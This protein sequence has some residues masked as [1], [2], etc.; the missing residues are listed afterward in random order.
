ML[1]GTLKVAGSLC[2]S[3]AAGPIRQNSARRI[4]RTTARATTRP[5]AA[6]GPRSIWVRYH[7]P[8]ENMLRNFSSLFTLFTR[9]AP[10]TANKIPPI[11]N[12]V[13]YLLLSVWAKRCVFVAHSLHPTGFRTTNTLG[14]IFFAIQNPLVAQMG[15]ATLEMVCRCHVWTPFSRFHTIGFLCVECSESYRH[16]GYA[17]YLRSISLRHSITLTCLINWYI[18]LIVCI[19]ILITNTRLHC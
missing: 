1:S 11:I 18:K 3:S 4:A 19:T 5:T 9:L 17:T 2:R 10:N 7:Y 15:Q 16:H 8:A 14:F 6:Y 12:A 13:D